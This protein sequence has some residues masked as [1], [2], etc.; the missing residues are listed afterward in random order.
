M[1]LA[2][3]SAT[4]WLEANGKAQFHCPNFQCTHTCESFRYDLTWDSRKTK[5]VAL[6]D[7]AYE[8]FHGADDFSQFVNWFTVQ[9]LADHYTM[10]W[11]D[12]RRYPCPRGPN[13]VDIEDPINVS[14]ASIPLHRRAAPTKGPN[15]GG[16]NPEGPP[17]PGEGARA[18]PGCVRSTHPAQLMY[19]LTIVGKDGDI[20]SVWL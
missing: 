7:R 11:V 18:R 12:L 14:V 17:T 3:Y 8:Y 15:P 5:F 20:C 2:H 16:P 1:R 9:N 4:S 13:T 10:D 19:K 6:A